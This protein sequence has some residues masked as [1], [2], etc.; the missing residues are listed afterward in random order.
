MPKSPRSSE[1]RQILRELRLRQFILHHNGVLFW[2]VSTGDHQPKVSKRP[3]MVHREG[4][5]GHRLSV[6][7]GSQSHSCEKHCAQRREAR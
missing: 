5:Q 2:K 4:R 7:P 3:E 1:Y 6:A